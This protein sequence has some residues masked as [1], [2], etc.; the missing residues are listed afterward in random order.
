MTVSGSLG[1]KPGDDPL[2]FLFESGTGNADRMVLAHSPAFAEWG[3][4]YQDVGDRFADGGD[5]AEALS[6]GTALQRELPIPLR[7]FVRSMRDMGAAVPTILML[8]LVIAL[9]PFLAGDDVQEWPVWVFL[10]M[11]ALTATPLGILAADLP[12]TTPRGS[13]AATQPRLLDG[14]LQ[15]RQRDSL[16]Q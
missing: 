1:F 4:A 13:T 15:C 14:R 9:L 3:L 7:V 12:E 11:A 16:G 8:W 6:T 2:I 5:L 10:M